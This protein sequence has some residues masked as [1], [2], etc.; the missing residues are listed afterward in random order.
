MSVTDFPSTPSA[1][2][3]ES[4]GPTVSGSPDGDVETAGGVI[5]S[6]AVVYQGE[7]DISFGGSLT[8]SLT[9]TSGNAEGQVVSPPIPPDQTQGV[10][11][12]TGDDTPADDPSITIDRPRITEVEVR[13]SNGNEINGGSRAKNKA[14]RGRDLRQ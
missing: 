10:Y 5:L 11:S 9:G 12:T 8:E 7:D 14:G 4:G 2:K 13:N 3:S 1:R 6:G